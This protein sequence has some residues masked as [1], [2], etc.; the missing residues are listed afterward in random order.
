MDCSRSYTTR[1]Q[2]DKW[3][4]VRTRLENTD[5][6]HNNYYNYD[7]YTSGLRVVRGTILQLIIKTI[8][9]L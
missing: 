9:E 8:D 1:R 3:L 5:D 7:Y 2:G 4:K 6:L